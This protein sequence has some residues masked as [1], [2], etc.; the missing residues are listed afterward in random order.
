M[1]LDFGYVLVRQL[2][3]IKL[4]DRCITGTGLFVALD[5]RAA[6]AGVAGN[7]MDAQRV[8]GWQ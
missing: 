8:V 4:Q 1:L 2:Q 7:G 6:T 5:R 3:P